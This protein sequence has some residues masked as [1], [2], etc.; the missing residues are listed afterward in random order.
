MTFALGSV[1]RDP[2]LCPVCSLHSPCPPSCVS[3][4]VPRFF[5]FLLDARPILVSAV[6]FEVLHTSPYP[7]FHVSHCFCLSV[8]SDQTRNR[9][10]FEDMGDAAQLRI[11]GFPQGRYVR[12]R[13]KALPAEFVTNFRCVAMHV[14]GRF[15]SD[16]CSCEAAAVQGQGQQ[17]CQQAVPT[18]SCA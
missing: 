9:K 11:R 18:T 4:T 5:V 16:G 12:I 14:E 2:F 17:R 3:P 15:P 6:W 1:K 10:E 8:A 7:P 13:F